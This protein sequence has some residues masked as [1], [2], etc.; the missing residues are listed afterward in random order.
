MEVL[1]NGAF[2]VIVARTEFANGAELQMR[3]RD[4]LENDRSIVELSILPITQVVECLVPQRAFVQFRRPMNKCHQGSPLLSCG[5]IA[6]LTLSPGGLWG[7]K[8]SGSSIPL[9]R[10]PSE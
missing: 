4:A 8:T 7:Q 6:A 5:Y 10:G 9:G 1:T 3:R 2:F